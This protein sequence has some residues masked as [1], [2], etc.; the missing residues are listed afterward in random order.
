[1]SSPPH[2][3]PSDLSSNLADFS[4]TSH[5][6]RPPNTQRFSLGA[7]GLLQDEDM[8]LAMGG[9]DLDDSF[10]L[11][12]HPQS[13]DDTEE[14]DETERLDREEEKTVKMSHGAK[15]SS[16]G[17]FE[18]GG[19]MAAST[20]TQP[21]SL[22]TSTSTRQAQLQTTPRRRSEDEGGEA[23]EE[24][25]QEEDELLIE[26]FSS[27]SEEDQKRIRELRAE[28]DELRGMNKILEQVV[29]SLKLTEGN[30][31]VRFFSLSL[32]P[33]LSTHAKKTLMREW[34]EECTA[35]SSCIFDFT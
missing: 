4:L 32:F 35:S 1:M 8:S 17:G 7:A 9:D 18:F 29:G 22:S 20:N 13:L 33:F 10:G 27:F 23:E 6:T 31:T 34:K 12:N 3:D 16:G 26:G 24:Q 19:S 14:A 5:R 2:A 30:M 25:E 15:G 11:F 28:R 21:F